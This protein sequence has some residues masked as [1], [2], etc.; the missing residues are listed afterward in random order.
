MGW[1]LFTEDLAITASL[2]RS[3]PP[4]SGSREES[5]HTARRQHSMTI[6]TEP[7]THT[8]RQAGCGGI[9]EWYTGKAGELCVSISLF[10]NVNSFPQPSSLYPVPQAALWPTESISHRPHGSCNPNM[11]LSCVCCRAKIT[12]FVLINVSTSATDIYMS[13][14]ILQASIGSTTDR[15]SKAG[16]QLSPSKV[17]CS[18]SRTWMWCIKTSVVEWFSLG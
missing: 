13:V 3:P 15:A 12:A 5:T 9:W 16:C 18:H 17:W 8:H 4:S 2:V 10:R 11:M 7:D 6:S 14:V 1:P